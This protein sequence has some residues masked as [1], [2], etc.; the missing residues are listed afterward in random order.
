MAEEPQSAPA[1]R[2]PVVAAVT[3][4]LNVMTALKRELGLLKGDDPV[5][6]TAIG[7]DHFGLRADSTLRFEHDLLSRLFEEVVGTAMYTSP[8]LKE[9]EAGRLILRMG[10][11]ARGR[12]LL[13][14]A[15]RAITAQLAP[16]DVSEHQVWQ[17]RTSAWAVADKLL[18]T[19]V[20]LDRAGL[21]AP[22]NG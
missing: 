18:R 2:R 20:E 16:T 11:P 19:D 7:P 21:W 15:E 22:C 4:S 1:E 9:T 8:D 3:G 10:P 5:T 12:V 13:A 14:A 6:T 17:S